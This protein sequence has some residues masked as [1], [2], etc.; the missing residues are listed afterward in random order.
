MKKIVSVIL[1]L[2]M[3]CGLF[4][5]PASAAEIENGETTHYFRDLEF[6]KDGKK[7]FKTQYHFPQERQSQQE[8]TGKTIA[9]I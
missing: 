4:A 6:T 2:A 1:V 8:P 5:L 3:A 9:I 7:S